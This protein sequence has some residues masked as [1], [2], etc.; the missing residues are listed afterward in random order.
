MRKCSVCQHPDADEI[1]ARL[2]GGQPLRNIA[3][4]FSV[5]LAAL[6]RHK[7][8]HLPAHLAKAQDAKDVACA[9]SL[10]AQV[11]TLQEK[12]LG[13]L[14]KAEGTGD[15]RG[16]TAAIREARECLALLAKLTG[17][18]DERAQV[19]VLVLSPEW[20][21]LRARILVALEPYP[22]ARLALV[23]ALGG[24]DAAR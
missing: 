20:L 18:L 19:N 15:L 8:Q 5:S 1:N 9:D 6:H 22:D 21:A 10:L 23:S 16:A 2:I 14:D 7:T 24:G 12:A 4:Q 13:I 17:E 3:E 11:R